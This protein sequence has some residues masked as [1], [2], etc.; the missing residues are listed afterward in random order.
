MK[1]TR[2]EVLGICGLGILV[3]VV[4]LIIGRT[5]TAPT[6]LA[7]PAWVPF[8]PVLTV[9]YALQVVG[10]FLLVFAVRD[11][12]LRM[13]C[14]KSYFAVM[15]IITI[16]WWLYPTVMHRPP[17]PTEWWNWPFRVMVAVDLPVNILPAGHIPMPVLICWAFVHDRPRW[18]RW[19]VPAELLGAI[20]IVV[21]WQHR[22]VDV[23]IGVALTVAAGLMF[24]V[25]WRRAAGGPAAG[26]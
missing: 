24:G 6:E 1:P 14:W 23:A 11:R 19:L 20:A 5:M 2:R 4:Y 18:L 26:N 17:T 15:T 12:E 25:G 16:F 13:A 10:S 8:V 22:P 9:P 21:T 3:Y 7:M